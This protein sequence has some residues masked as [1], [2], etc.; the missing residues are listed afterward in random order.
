MDTDE[1]NLNRRDRRRLNVVRRVVAG[2]ITV[3]Q[4]AQALELSERQMWRLVAAYRRNSCAGLLHGNRGR[5]PAHAMKPEVRSRVVE[6]ARSMAEGCTHSD[7]QQA[8]RT[9]EAINI[10]LSSIRNILVEAGI[11]HRPGRRPRSQERR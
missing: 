10:S 4:A 8:L 5:T 3:A 7:I 9:Q 1:S 11:R 2:K 6:V